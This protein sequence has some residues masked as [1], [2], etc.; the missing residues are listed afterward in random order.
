[1]SCA[2]NVIE[3]WYC[4]RANAA[5]ITMNTMMSTRI[6]ESWPFSLIFFTT[7]P[8]STSSVSVEEDV[9]TSEDKVDMEAES[10]STMTMPMSKSGRVESIVG[11]IE[12]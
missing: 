5:E 7:L 2:M 6:V 3:E 1:M 10:T 4:T 8:L 12:S 9:S 11:M